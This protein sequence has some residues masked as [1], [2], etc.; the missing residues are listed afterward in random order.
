MFAFFNLNF[1]ESNMNQECLANIIY[2]LKIQT[3]VLFLLRIKII[4]TYLQLS[5]HYIL[6]LLVRIQEAQR[7]CTK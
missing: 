5:H 1:L 2:I 7:A 3:L 4:K 6:E